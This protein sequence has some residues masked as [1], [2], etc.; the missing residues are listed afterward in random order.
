VY[1]PGKFV[2]AYVPK[3][4]ELNERNDLV[5]MRDD[6]RMFI[7]RQIAGIIA[8]KIR[9]W[10][11]EGSLIQVGSRYGM[12][13]FGSRVDILLPSSVE[14]YITKGQHVYG[15]QTVIGRWLCK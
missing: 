14:L 2:P 5:V 11:H 4:S 8:R 13:M 1:K 10:V 12:I 7:V 6:G 15:A 3:S 9:S